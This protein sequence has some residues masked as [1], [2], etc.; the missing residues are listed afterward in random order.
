MTTKEKQRLLD[1][2]DRQIEELEK[3]RRQIDSGS[4]HLSSDGYIYQ[5]AGGGISSLRKFLNDTG[6]RKY[7]EEQ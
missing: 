4:C 2:A 1:V 5:G 7:D 6:L 3:C